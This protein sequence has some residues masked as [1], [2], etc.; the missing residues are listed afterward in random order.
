MEHFCVKFGDPSSSVFEISHAKKDRQINGIANP[1]P[2]L[3]DVG[4]G[5]KVNAFRKW[6]TESSITI[7]KMVKFR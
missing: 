6:Y 1:T 3:H 2:Q 4:V 7:A 5:N